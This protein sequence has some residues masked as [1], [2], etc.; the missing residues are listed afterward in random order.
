MN[1]DPA[2]YLFQVELLRIIN[3]VSVAFLDHLHVTAQRQVH[4]INIIQLF[5][6]FG[7]TFYFR[8]KKAEKRREST[9]R[10][11]KKDIEKDVR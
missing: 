1:G 2:T 6:G 8:K 10:Q 9:H 5:C 3:E 11:G 7:V 4:H